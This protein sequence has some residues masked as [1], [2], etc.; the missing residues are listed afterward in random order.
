MRGRGWS[1]R[2]RLA[3]DAERLPGPELEGNAVHGLDVVHGAVKDALLDGEPDLQ[4]VGFKHHRRGFIHQGS[5][6]LGFSLDKPLRVRMF[7]GRK[8]FL[9]WPA[10]HDLAV[11]HHAGAVRHLSHDA[12]VVRDEEGSAMPSSR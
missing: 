3:D 2:S 4:V 9:G 5:L 10:L 12:E 11:L 1:C 8:D 7:R 6:P